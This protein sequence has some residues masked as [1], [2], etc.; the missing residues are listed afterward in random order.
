MDFFSRTNAYFEKSET[1]DSNKINC[2]WCD[3]IIS[4]NKGYRVRCS[5]HSIVGYIYVCPNC[6]QISLFNSYKSIFPKSKYGKAVE[7]LPNDVAQ[8]YDECRKCFSIGAYTSISLLARKL[9]MHIGVKEGAEENKPFKYYVDFLVENNYVPPKSKHLLEFIRNQG[10]EATHEIIVK[11][12]EDAKKIVDF[13]S[14]ILIFLY[15]YA[16]AGVAE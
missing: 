5:S 4:P 15:E 16:D 7:K 9:L 13:V 8:I 11:N 12:E 10:N 3:S 2:G 14:M 6:N 1:I